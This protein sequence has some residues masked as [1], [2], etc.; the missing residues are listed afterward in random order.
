[1]EI[2]LSS[3]TRYPVYY[4]ILIKSISYNKPTRHADHA[5]RF[6]YRNIRS[7][8]MREAGVVKSG[9]QIHLKFL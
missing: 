4:D 9:I 6:V 2:L 8:L 7:T 1:M 3:Y 5:M